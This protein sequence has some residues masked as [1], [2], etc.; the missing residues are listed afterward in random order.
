VAYGRKIYIAGELQDRVV[1]G[2]W[3]TWE[4]EGG[5][6][7]AGLTLLEPFN[8]LEDVAIDADVQFRYDTNTTWWRGF[9][10]DW[11]STLTGGLRVSCRG[12]K[13]L[14]TDSYPGDV[15]ELKFGSD[16]AVGERT[17][18]DTDVESVV[19]YFADNWL[20]SGIGKGTI[21]AGDDI[22]LTDFRLDGT[23]DL[24]ET[25]EALSDIVG[26]VV[27]G[28][29]ETKDFYFR[30][31]RTSTAQTFYFADRNETFEVMQASRRV[32]RKGYNKLIIRGGE[33]ADCSGQYIGV[34]TTGDGKRSIALMIP[35]INNDTDGLLFANNF[36]GKHPI[37][38]DV[39]SF[40][41]LNLTS[42][43]KPSDGV[44]KIYD[45]SRKS[46]GSFHINSVRYAF[47]ETTAAGFDI[48]GVTRAQKPYKKRTRQFP[49]NQRSIERHIGT[50]VN[51]QW[52]KYTGA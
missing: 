14:L 2:A 20:P 43:V 37:T 51:P 36:F 47:D 23:M 44:V 45:Q 19:D 49:Q 29:D 46:I 1:G 6:S 39:Y 5:C 48:A 3:F 7:E 25:I 35:G 24:L 10:D 30:A 21:N 26:D 33:L 12:Y 32:S 16:I 42:L 13:S 52:V 27:W 50:A 8:R 9:I 4:R 17:I 31:A 38:P 40:E 22:D 41:A 34:F 15:S 11:E 18:A 28:V